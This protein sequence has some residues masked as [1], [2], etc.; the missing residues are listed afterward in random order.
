[1]HTRQKRQEILSAGR[2]IRRNRKVQLLRRLVDLD[3]QLAAGGITLAAFAAEHGVTVAIV[4]SDLRAFEEMGQVISRRRPPGERAFRYC[5]FDVAQ[6]PLFTCH[7]PEP[8][9]APD[10]GLLAD[11]PVWRF[12]VSSSVS[13]YVARLL[14]HGPC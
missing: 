5:Y 10:G 4:R 9:P 7:T 1:M 14:L 6:R 2:R 12:A 13:S 8:R 11:V 3:R